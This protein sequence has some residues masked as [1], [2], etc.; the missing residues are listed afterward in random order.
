MA[1]TTLAIIAGAVGGAS[2]LIVWFTRRHER[3]RKEALHEEHQNLLEAVNDALLDGDSIA[4]T[5]AERRL[6]EF[7]KRHGYSK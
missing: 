7:E 4:L 3:K 5:D 6:F 1:N 2:A